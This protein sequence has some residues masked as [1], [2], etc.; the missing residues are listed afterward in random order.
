MAGTVD[1]LTGGLLGG[2]ELRALKEWEWD[3]RC[4][5]RMAEGGGGEG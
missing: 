1:G 4:A 2:S 3:V 5:V